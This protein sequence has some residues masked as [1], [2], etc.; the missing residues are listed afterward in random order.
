[1]KYRNVIRIKSDN[2]SV[3]YANFIVVLLFYDVWEMRYRLLNSTLIG[4]HVAGGVGLIMIILMMLLMIIL[5]ITMIWYN[6]YHH[7]NNDDVNKNNNNDDDGDTDTNIDTD[8]TSITT[9]DT[10]HIITW[11]ILSLEL[12]MSNNGWQR[13]R[14]ARVILGFWNWI[15]SGISWKAIL[16]GPWHTS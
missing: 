9:T 3:Y 15:G 1:M 10:N 11:V 16:Q 4:Q 14:P 12:F 2:S 6:G 5:T 7:D 8:T 13:R